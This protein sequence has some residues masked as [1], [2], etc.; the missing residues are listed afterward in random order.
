MQVQVAA[1]IDQ[2]PC[3]LSLAGGVFLLCI[4]R[5]FSIK[6]RAFYVPTYIRIY[7]RYLDVAV[8]HNVDCSSYL[9]TYMYLRYLIPSTH[10]VFTLL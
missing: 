1:Q 10:A 8:L 3:V 7:I 2:R 4:R 6:W 9:P 5:Y